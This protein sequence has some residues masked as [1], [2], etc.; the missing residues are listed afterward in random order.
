MEN[1][2]VLLGKRIKEIR[3][4]KKLTQEKLAELAG[5]ETPSL[6]NIENGKNYPGNETLFKLS[7]ALNVKPYELY[8]FEHEKSIENLTEEINIMLKRANYDEIKLIYKII[9]TILN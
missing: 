5:I 3:K 7:S 9:S 2:K 6:S 1:I 4:Q 8:K